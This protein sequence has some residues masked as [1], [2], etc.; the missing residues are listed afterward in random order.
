MIT[1]SKIL[2]FNP[3]DI[4]SSDLESIEKEKKVEFFFDNLFV[5]TKAFKQYQ[6]QLLNSITPDGEFL[7]NLIFIHGY[8][9]NG[10]TTFL[11]WFKKELDDD[12]YF[13]IVNINSIPASSNKTVL[14]KVIYYKIK[15]LINSEPFQSVKYYLDNALEK[16]DFLSVDQILY[17]HE[18]NELLSRK[19]S[20]EKE[21]PDDFKE[22]LKVKK[23]LESFK[24]MFS[25][26][27]ILFLYILELIIRNHD[28]NYKS[29]T[30]VFDNLDEIAFEYMT[31]DLWKDFKAVRSNLMIFFDDHNAKF[32]FSRRFIF[33]LVFR[34]A[35]LL[36]NASHHEERIDNT[37]KSIKLLLADSNLKKS[38]SGK[39]VIE[40]RLLYL[41]R[42]RNINTDS[43]YKLANTIVEESYTNR[44][45]FPLFNYDYRKLMNMVVDVA[46]YEMN[47]NKNNFIPWRYK[48]FK[49][50]SPYLA[51]GMFFHRIIDY[52]LKKGY[53]HDLARKPDDQIIDSNG[54]CRPSRVL[55]TI[56]FRLSYPKGLPKDEFLLHLEKPKKIS[57]VDLIE[58]YFKIYN[59][60]TLFFNDLSLL[61]NISKG[62]WAHLISIYNKKISKDSNY[63]ISFS[64][65]KSVVE[66]WLIKAISFDQ[67][68]NYFS[69]E[70]NIQLHLN[71]S[72]YI[73]LRYIITHFE[74]FTT[75]NTYRNGGKRDSLFE[76]FKNLN[77]LIK[78]EKFEFEIL[79]EEVLKKLS[80]YQN[81]TTNFLKNVVA[82]TKNISIHEYLNNTNYTFLRSNQHAPSLY[83]TR[84][85]NTHLSYIEEL[86]KFLF[87]KE[88]QKLIS[89]LNNHSIKDLNLIIIK[90]MERYINLLEKCDT[91]DS[92][93]VAYNI[94]E[95]SGNKLQQVKNGNL[96]KWTP[97]IK[98]KKN[99]L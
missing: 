46:E 19:R 81:N 54:Y 68:K 29:L 20:L 26:R 77:Y 92:D 23:H 94:I 97:I 18:Y 8:S 44:V 42:T 16:H 65:E 37:R 56:I 45:F 85:I 52:L 78:E 3:F 43:V 49:K 36:I 84:V 40:Q 59:N 57:I 89:K 31:E 86:R 73:Y 50:E 62:S 48:N 7:K 53:I 38:S 32:D 91:H 72:G 2:K 67:L 93:K 82:K 88:G 66:N 22:K 95:K 90:L 63:E 41:R 87:T 10:K 39:K 6:Q 58:E 99:Y 25:N 34:E 83:F 80:R 28:K 24:K 4:E 79:I 96:Y 75:L 64:E 60:A 17:L 33:L 13:D 47:S 11:N 27:E 9:G 51:R 5:E 14:S 69:E 70:N 71:A 76:S 1:T 98:N 15:E 30:I 61:F 55:L 12:F 74:Y 35:N 21:K